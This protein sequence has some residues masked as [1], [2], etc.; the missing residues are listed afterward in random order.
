MPLRVADG[1]AVRVGCC[2]AH[3]AVTLRD[4]GAHEDAISMP[5][6]NGA[7]HTKYDGHATA[8]NVVFGLAVVQQQRLGV[9]ERVPFSVADG[10]AVRVGC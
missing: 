4:N 6:A 8:I 10:V 1:V 7:A 5:L 9:G 2:V 3:A